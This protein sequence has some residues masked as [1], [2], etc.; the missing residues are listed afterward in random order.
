MKREELKQIAELTDEQLDKIMAING[1]DVEKVKAKVAALEADLKEAKETIDKTN[2]EFEALKSSNAGAEE[3]KTKYEA[4]V[5][6]NE[7]KAKQAEAERILREK[8]ENISNRFNTVLKDKKFSH[9]AI[10]EAYLKKFGEA[11]ESKDFEG[12]SDEQIIHTLTKDDATAFTGVTAVKLQGGR[13]MGTGKYSSKEDIMSIK[14][15]ALRRAEMLAN[16]HLFP[17][18]NNN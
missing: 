1:A 10:R 3:Y 16:P 4:L 8:T 9:D 2:T 17:E 5:A 15:G 14:D 11:L 18:L 7:A 6:E 13:P 12:Q